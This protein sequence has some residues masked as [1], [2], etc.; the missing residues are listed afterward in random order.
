MKA[1][2]YLR[3]YT[4]SSNR[5]ALNMAY[6]YH[7]YWQGEKNYHVYNGFME[8]IWSRGKMPDKDSL[9]LLNELA[10]FGDDVEIVSLYD[11]GNFWGWGEA[12]RQG[13]IKFPAMV[14]NGKKIQGRVNCELYLKD[15]KERNS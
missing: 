7:Y 4:L 15:I 9:W 5:D 13:F 6:D 11:V 12:V 10:D 3:F 1:V 14:S 8:K 2:L